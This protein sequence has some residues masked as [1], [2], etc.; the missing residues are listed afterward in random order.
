[1]FHCQVTSRKDQ[2]QYWADSS[3]PYVFISVPEIAE[4]FKNSRFGRS[5]QSSLSV[6]YDESDIPTDDGW[7]S[8][9][10][11]VSELKGSAVIVICGGYLDSTGSTSSESLISNM[12]LY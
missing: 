5:L 6:P 7:K 9:A 3:K 8:M 4:A 2:A 11:D 10:V 12:R 1:M